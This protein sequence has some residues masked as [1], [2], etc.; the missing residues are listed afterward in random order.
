MPR[1]G[2]RLALLIGAAVLLVAALATLLWVVVRDQPATVLATAAS[3]TVDEGS[4]AVS[5]S[6]TIGGLPLVG[7]VALSVAEGELD[8]ARQRADLRR[9]M[10]FLSSVGGLPSLEMGTVELRFANGGAWVRGPADEG[11]WVGVADP[12]DEAIASAPGLGDPRAL[13]DLVRA[14]ESLPDEVG[15]AVIDGV[16]VVRYEVVV[17]LAPLASEDEDG[18]AASLMSVHEG[19]VL[20]VEVWVDDERLIRRV[21]YDLRV[22][23][24]VGLPLLEVRTD[25]D[26]DRHGLPVSIERPDPDDVVEAPEGGLG[27]LGL[28]GLLRAW[29]EGRPGR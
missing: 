28:L 27:D 13:L 14:I 11:S 6:A 12:T 15:E 5:I 7:D 20:P 19:D 25:V 23:V 21:R 16:E 3:R 10:P 2:R 29:L 22:R 18:L 9:E 26:L 4:A 1:Y 8:L 24:A 17:D